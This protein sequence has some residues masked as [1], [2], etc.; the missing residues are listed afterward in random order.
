M[1][2][3]YSEISKSDQV[4]QGD[5]I[6]NCPILIPPLS[7]EPKDIE[8]ID[9]T[10]IDSIILSQSC[11][12]VNNKIQIVLVCPYYPLSRFIENLPD[13][14]K[15]KKALRKHIDNLKKGYLPGYHLLNKNSEL[16]FDDYFVVDFRN[17]YGVH[18]DNIRNIALSLDNRIRLM[19]PYREHLSQAFAR[20]FMRV[21]LP[22]DINIE[23]Y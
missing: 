19:P 12:L 15:S 2:F 3:W 8:E 23:G 21:G 13:E 18:V 4:E 6:P 7:V 20:Y 16:K 11:D 5:F 9:I 22:Q 17:V 1:Y 14:Q 10:L